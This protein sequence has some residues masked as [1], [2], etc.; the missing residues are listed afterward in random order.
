MSK[1]IKTITV[2]KD[3][4]FTREE[5]DS[6]S[7]IALLGKYSDS[8]TIEYEKETAKFPNGAEVFAPENGTVY[9]S[10]D[11]DT[12]NILKTSW[13]NSSIGSLLLTNQNVFLEKEKCE[14]SGK[15][16]NRHFELVQKIYQINAEYNWVADWGN[17]NQYKHF[18]LWIHASGNIKFNVETIMQGTAVYFCHPAKTYLENLSEEDQKAFLLIYT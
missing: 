7:L 12:G 5:L 17:C 18:A 15:L 2:K 1:I 3:A 8:C 16:D 10:H 11:L 14:S 9:Y 6:N 4:T 13:N